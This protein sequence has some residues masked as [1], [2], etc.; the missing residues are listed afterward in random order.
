MGDK[1]KTIAMYLP[2]YHQIPENDEWWGE[3]YT[4]W[5]AV[6]TA[7]RYFEGQNQPR[8]PLNENYYDL[9]NKASLLWQADLMKKYNV[10]GLCFYHY[11]FK[12]GR[13]VL[14]KPAEILLYN[15]D[16]EMPF[17]FCWANDPWARSWSK[18]AN[19]NQWAEKFETTIKEQKE[20]LLEQDYGAEAEWE[21]H[22]KYLL[23]F[24]EDDRYIKI[25]D[26]PLFIFYRPESVGP[27]EDMINYF[28]S[29]IKE[30]GFKG[31]CFWGA[32][33][34]KPMVGLEGILFIHAS[35]YFN[36]DITGMFLQQ[37]RINNIRT[38][39][40]DDVWNN[41]IGSPDIHGIKTFFGG[42]VDQD[43]TPRRGKLGFCLTDVTPDKFKHYFYRLVVKNMFYKNPFVFID[44]WNEWG[45]GSYLEP[46]SVNGYAYL[47]AVKEV[48]DICNDDLF[49]AEKEWDKIKPDKSNNMNDLAIAKELKKYKQF[50]RIL[51]NWMILKEKNYSIADY[52]KYKGYSTIAI[53]GFM[54]LGNHLYQ[55]LVNSDVKISTIIDRREGLKCKGID[56]VTPG[57]EIINVDAI[58]VTPVCEY[59]EIKRNLGAFTNAHI[60]SIEEVVNG[61]I[62]FGDN[63]K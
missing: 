56:I 32:N 60:L 11:Y 28:D 51:N 29:R 17:C 31:I 22:F 23:P 39:S 18:M 21:E 24:F 5:T 9:S 61:C 12:N 36:V 25:E 13:K 42:I 53:Y 49:D 7:E 55:E 54:A 6:K 16:I 58:I 26:K 46:D 34:S 2:Q 37:K 44:A 14:E 59:V 1:I 15:K 10:G 27:L 63:C 8:I 33:V 57:C 47:E 48:M 35:A 4:D 62:T 45:E 52:L 19:T 50:Y 30:H 20:V 41:I 43:D 40:Y 38:Y 3:G